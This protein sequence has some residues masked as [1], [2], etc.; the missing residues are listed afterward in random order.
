M[1]VETMVEIAQIKW[2]QATGSS[3]SPTTA[4]KFLRTAVVH[5]ESLDFPSDIEYSIADGLLTFTSEPS[6]VS[7]LLYVYKALLDL[8]VSD[9]GQKVANNEIGL[10]WRSGMDSIS[11]VG[12]GK[13]A[14]A[15]IA[16]FEK[17]YN[18][19]LSLAKLGE[20]GM[21]DIDLYEDIEIV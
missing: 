1:T 11:S 19:A 2:D 15:L 21:T 18:D 8:Q 12:A 20:L 7:G 14:S 3:L 16:S 9:V 10:N 4:R 5:V 6:D 13:A 17:Q